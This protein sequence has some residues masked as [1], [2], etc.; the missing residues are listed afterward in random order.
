MKNTLLASWYVTVKPAFNMKRIF[1]LIL[2]NGDQYLTEN[3]VFFLTHNYTKWPRNLH[4]FLHAYSSANKQS[5][6]H[7]FVTV[8]LSQNHQC[9]L[10]FGIRD[11]Q[12]H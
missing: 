11:T 9:T 6:C 7:F 3:T 8:S 10:G 5:I 2:A 1:S 12:I 4:T